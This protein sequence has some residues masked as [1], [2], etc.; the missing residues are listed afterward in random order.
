[1]E[2]MIDFTARRTSDLKVSPPSIVPDK[3]QRRHKSGLSRDRREVEP[4]ESAVQAREA[5]EFGPKRP[6]EAPDAGRGGD[7]LDD[8]E[9]R[10]GRSRS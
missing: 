9:F 7:L 8:R 10:H 4:P 6:P 5:P 2:T 1:M 3:E